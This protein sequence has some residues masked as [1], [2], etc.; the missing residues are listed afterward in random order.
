MAAC[1]A[2][3]PSV[4]DILIWGVVAILLQLLAFRV[5]DLVLRDLPKRIERDEDRRRP[6]A[7][8]REDC[9]CDGNGGGLVSWRA[10]TNIRRTR[11]RA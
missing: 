3:A 9:C 10:R 11:R 1:L 8:G 4:Y 5:A 2:T 6:G 7:G